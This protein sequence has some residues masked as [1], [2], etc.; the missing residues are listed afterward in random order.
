[1]AEAA[2][3]PNGLCRGHTSRCNPPRQDCRPP[4]QRLMWDIGHNQIDDWMVDLRRLSCHASASNL[5][6]SRGMGASMGTY[7]PRGGGMSAWSTVNLSPTWLP[8]RIPSGL[9]NDGSLRPLRHRKAAVQP[10][11]SETR[12]RPRRALLH[13]VSVDTSCTWQSPS[14]GFRFPL[15]F[16]IVHVSGQASEMSRNGRR[17]L[18]FARLIVQQQAVGGIDDLGQAGRPMTARETSGPIYATKALWL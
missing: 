16:V 8:C 1:M 6:G 18:P 9:P 12:T 15:D 7:G 11:P 4:G 3:S 5:W 14:K 10:E 13:L 2:H 17:L